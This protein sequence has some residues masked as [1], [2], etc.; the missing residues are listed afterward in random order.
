MKILIYT[1]ALMSAFFVSAQT[2]LGKIPATSETK[3]TLLCTVN[4]SNQFTVPQDDTSACE[5]ATL[6]S[7]DTSLLPSPTD[8]FSPYVPLGSP[9]CTTEQI[10]F[11]RYRVTCKQEYHSVSP[12]KPDV[13]LYT[14]SSLS[15][16][17]SPS[18]GL[19]YQCKN[20]DFPDGPKDE[21]DGHWCY[22][23][24]KQ[25]EPEPCSEFGNNSFLPNK[26][27]VGQS[28][29]NACYTNPTTGQQCQFKQ[30]N[31]NFIATG[32]SCDGDEND[33]GDKPTPEPTPD[34]GDDNCYNYGSQGQVLI[35][36]VDPNEGCNAIVVSGQQQYQ[37]PHG[38]GSMDGV[39]FCTYDDKDGDGIP[40]DKNGNGVPDKDETCENGKC[41]PNRPDDNTTPTPETPDMTQTNTRL[42][43][44]IGE[45]DSIGGN[46]RKTNQTLDGINSGIQGIKQGQDKSNGLLSGVEKNTK[47]TAENTDVIA[48]NTKGI[49]DSISETDIGDT[50]NPE[51]SSS[52]YESAYENGWQGVWDEKSDLISQTGLFV[53]LKQFRLT[54][55]GS[56]PE[57]N[58]CFDV[59]VNLGCKTLD[60]NWE[61]LMPFLRICIFITT[62]F[63]CRRIIFGG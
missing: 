30:G 10:R 9:S 56:A 54:S 18:T 11:D 24:E 37:C 36:D 23:L 61:R 50:F 31:D 63:V 8:D 1:L 22:E 29:E 49:L 42:D 32:K 13:R 55:G 12:T 3:P 27:G 60:P 7:L 33:Y 34:G 59:L 16:L 21:F 28:G 35:C 40:D 52:F 14:L 2:Q 57:M 45:L 39:Y 47:L 6:S 5:S 43:S 15:S 51:G 48:G 4:S 62:A 44:V 20:P 19:V 38:C 25:P 53:F 41:T 46:I 17:T 58:I 26:S